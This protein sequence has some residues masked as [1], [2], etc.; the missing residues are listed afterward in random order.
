M[1]VQLPDGFHAAVWDVL[2]NRL[3][4]PSRHLGKVGPQ[5]FWEFCQAWP[6]CV[7]YRFMGT[8]GFG[9]KVWW[10]ESV[11]IAPRCWVSGY[12]EDMTPERLDA[13]KAANA[14]LAAYLRT[15]GLVRS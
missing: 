13:I 5:A 14:D 11:A 1:R 7:E 10:D 9:G 3:G 15:S 12:P 8:L 2:A 6:A 4:V